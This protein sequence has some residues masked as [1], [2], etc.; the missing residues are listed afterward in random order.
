MNKISMEKKEYEQFFK[1]L[2]YKNRKYTAKITFLG[3]ISN[4]NQKHLEILSVLLQP[5]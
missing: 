5:M 2:E 3:H 4:K 1:K